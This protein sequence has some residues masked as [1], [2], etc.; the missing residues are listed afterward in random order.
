MRS[1]WRGADKSLARPTSRC[2]VTESIVSL[3]R[4]VCSCGELLVFSCY[5]GWKEACQATRAISTTSRREFSSSFFFP[6]RQGAEGNSR[7]SDKNIRRTC[8]ILCH[9][10]KLGGPFNVVIF[11][12]VMS[13]VLDDSKQWPPRILLIKFTS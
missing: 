11:P 10:Q 1:V 3:E 13:L 5:R 4:G 2:H 12:P 8:T 9:R 7:H 6:A